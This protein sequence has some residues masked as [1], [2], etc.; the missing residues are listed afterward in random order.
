MR[1]TQNEGTDPIL[2]RK[3]RRK[4][5]MDDKR[6]NIWQKKFMLEELNEQ[7][8]KPAPAPPKRDLPASGGTVPGVKPGASPSPSPTPTPTPT[9]KPTPAPTPAPGPAPQP[10]RTPPPKPAPARSPAPVHPNRPVE[11]D[12]AITA[13]QESYDERMRKYA[14][15]RNGI[16]NS[17]TIPQTEK[18]NVLNAID[19]KYGLD[20]GQYQKWRVVDENR[21]KLKA[22]TDEVNSLRSGANGLLRQ[23]FDDE[24]VDDARRERERM[25]KQADD[26]VK[27]FGPT[28]AGLG[29]REIDPTRV[30][31]ITLDGKPVGN[32]RYVDGKATGNLGDVVKGLGG[33]VVWNKSQTG[34]TIY[35]PDGNVVS[36]LT[37]NNKFIFEKDAKG[38]IIRRYP[39]VD[40]EAQADIEEVAD[41]F[42]VPFSYYHDKNGVYRAFAQPE[43]RGAP[44]T[45]VRKEGDVYI[46]A[47]IDFDGKYADQI[48]PGTEKTDPATGKT[49]PGTGMTYAEVTAQGIIN[50]WGNGQ[51]FNVGGQMT[52]KD[53]KGND[54]L[55]DGNPIAYYLNPNDTVRTHVAIYSDSESGNGIIKKGKQANTKKNKVFIRDPLPIEKLLSFRSHVFTADDVLE[56]IAELPQNVRDMRNSGQLERVLYNWSLQDP[57]TTYIYPET[58]VASQMQT[59]AHESTHTFGVGDAYFDKLFRPKEAPRVI[60][61]INIYGQDTRDFVPDNDM[62]RSGDTVSDIDMIMML[63]ASETGKPQYFPK[64]DDEITREIQKDGIKAIIKYIKD[65]TIRFR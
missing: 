45:V 21:T 44:I 54:I 11:F 40:G 8:S 52:V 33:D 43:M 28:V 36:Y 62:A 41:K 53:S 42:A 55:N 16:L 50:K 3:R 64:G 31:D 34:G 18:G 59:G 26:T 17:G 58:D 2:E 10:S 63:R 6:L 32:A 25:R 15:E 24:V 9:P 48:Y 57:G 38:N 22:K 60:N 5:I 61:G 20:Q 30:V 37:K 4:E 23:R 56:G 49:I 51:T 19:K 39:L 46:E 7:E 35:D 1:T 14:A 27:G 12:D 47:N 29:G 65:G 13:P